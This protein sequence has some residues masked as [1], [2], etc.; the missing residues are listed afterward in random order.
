MTKIT[1]YPVGNG[2]TLRLDLRDG[3]KV[4]VDYADMKNRA[5]RTDKRID[6]PAA[7]R[8]D[9]RLAGR[10]YHDI[11]AFTHL[12]K[13]H[14]VGAGEFFEFDHADKY[15]GGGRIK[16][17]TMWVPASALTDVGTDG[18]ARLI[19]EEAKHRMREGYGIRV[20]SRPDALK[21]W[22]ERE[23]LDIASRMKFITNAGELVPGFG[24][25][26]GGGVEFFIHSPFG[27][28]RNAQE[29]DDRNLN[30]LVFQA[31]F[32]EGLT[33]V[34]ALFTADM[35]WQGLDDIVSITRNEAH[36]NDERLFW[37]FAKLPHHS[38]YLSLSE[39]KGV[40]QTVPTDNIKW[41][42]EKAGQKSGILLSS[43]WPVPSKGTEEDKNPQPPHR[44]A[45]NFYR[46]VA[47]GLNGRYEVTMEQPASNPRPTV[48]EI[49][50]LGARLVSNALA[51]AAAIAATP[52][53]AG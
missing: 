23:K 24:K 48:V 16:M 44:Q 36:S 8:A 19:R 13:D 42:Y 51:P 53:R 43:S 2:D 9:L 35:T 14:N 20:F 7:L 25:F 3:R 45:A 52:M 10:D 32:R 1:A 18:C 22:F 29:V 11:T 34:R 40:D 17:P 47:A 27:F 12:D 38:S 50:P 21:G 37:D 30:S 39:D 33:D 26:D 49:T 6:L 4:L 41:L 28:R 15:Q 5:D 31:T 46:K